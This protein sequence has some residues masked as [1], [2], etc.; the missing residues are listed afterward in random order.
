MNLLINKTDI[1][2]FKII[3]KALSVDKT[4]EYIRE[5]Q[6]IDLME[7][8]PRLFYFDL[9]KNFQSAKYQK[10]IHGDT[11]TV[12]GV[13][14]DFPG[15][16]GVLAYF[17][18]SRLVIRGDV[19]STPFGIEQKRN[20]WGDRVS[21]SEKRDMRDEARQIANS[22]FSQV[23]E[24]IMEKKADFPLFFENECK[25]RHRNNIKISKI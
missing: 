10:L 22:Y 13:D 6:E 20:E 15:L 11:Y 25:Q 19:V 8:V 12:D 4:D 16:K 2:D 23:V 17:A 1:Q 14:I 5:A 9:V 24:Y 3:S 7:L 21:S 18:Y